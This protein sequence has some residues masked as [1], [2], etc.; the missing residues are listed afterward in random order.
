MLMSFQVVVVELYVGV[1]SH[2]TT[3]RKDLVCVSQGHAMIVSKA[4]VFDELGA[5]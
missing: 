4:D 2:F 1:D 5:T 3:P